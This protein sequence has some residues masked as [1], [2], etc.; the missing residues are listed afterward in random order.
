MTIKEMKTFLLSKKGLT[1]EERKE[2]NQANDK[3]I[4]D[5]FS[6]F[7]KKVKKP[8]NSERFTDIWF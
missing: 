8:Q 6:E 4:K 1:P 5:L 7:K 3:D 2:I